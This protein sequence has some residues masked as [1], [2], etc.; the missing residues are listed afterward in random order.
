MAKE[1]CGQQIGW[2]LRVYNDTTLQQ[3]QYLAPE[4]LAYDVKKLKLEN[5]LWEG[6]WRCF[7][8]DIVDPKQALVW[9]TKGVLYI[10]TWGVSAI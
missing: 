10:E 4:I 2:V 3:A 1:Q 9:N 6:S 8:Y 5:P 7:L